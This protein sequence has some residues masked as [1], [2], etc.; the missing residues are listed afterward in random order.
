MTACDEIRSLLSAMIDNEL[1]AEQMTRASDHLRQCSACQ[2]E[3]QSLKSLD[4]QLRERLVLTGVNGKSIVEKFDNLRSGD[5]SADDD[6]RSRSPLGA[7]RPSTATPVSTATP[8]FAE[9]RNIRKTLL[10]V[11]AMAASLVGLL[12]LRDQ[13]AWISPVMPQQ[14]AEVDSLETPSSR[15]VARLVRATGV[16][17]MQLQGSSRWDSVMTTPETPLVQGC[18]LRTGDSVLCE[19]ETADRAKIR[20]NETGEVVFRDAGEIELIKG[21]LWCLASERSGIEIDLSVESKPVPQIA[22][23]T[24]P[25]ESEFQCHTSDQGAS[26]DSVSLDNSLAEMS[27][28]AETCLIEPGE[29][30]SINEQR[31][32]ART[33]NGSVDA[34]IWQLPLLAVG[35]SIDGELR[36]AL[37][38]LLAPIGMTKVR[39]M[40][41]EQIRRLGPAGAIP[42]LAYAVTETGADNLRLRQTAVS[43]AHDFADQRS[44]EL[45]KRL[46]ADPDSVIS[47]QAERTLQRISQSL[48]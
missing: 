44:I 21:Q 42:L 41:E 19:I 12:A 8:P 34:K 46:A 10:V 9:K 24:C 14:N 38:R 1:T 18:R 26:C 25:S 5:S 29:T 4:A 37:N 35:E 6:L 11:V 15:V 39:H 23:F 32:I 43:L 27:Y 7:K 17:E 30:V 48:Q 3:W 22:S 13:F 31:R 20:L 28:G 40:N 47:S 33:P 2:R 36:S 45:L 16:V